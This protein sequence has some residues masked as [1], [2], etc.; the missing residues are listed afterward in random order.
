MAKVLSKTF[1]PT[2]TT[3]LS[4]FLR[5]LSHGYEGSGDFLLCLEPGLLALVAGQHF[6]LAIEGLTDVDVEPRRY[7]VSEDVASAKGIDIVEMRDCGKGWRRVSKAR[8]I[9]RSHRAE[10]CGLSETAYR[11][12]IEHVISRRMREDEGRLYLADE[13]H[14]F[15]QMQMV[16]KNEQVFPLE[17]VVPG[18]D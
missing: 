7:F 11:L 16:I 8:L 18:P 10:T 3:A 17:T 5:H 12:M 2:E 1:C 13:F 4:N 9:V 6:L 14:H 15:V